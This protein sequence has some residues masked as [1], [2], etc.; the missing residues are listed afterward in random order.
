MGVAVDLLILKK[1]LATETGPAS[2]YRGTERAHP[3]HFTNLAES[4]SANQL[5]S[6]FVEE[7][8]PRGV[9][10]DV[11]RAKQLTESLNLFGDSVF[12]EVVQVGTER[13]VTSG[14]GGFL[15]F[16]V[17]ATF[18]SSLLRRLLL[19]ES[20]PELRRAADATFKDLS[21]LH[22]VH[23][24]QKLNDHRLFQTAE[25]AEFFLRAARALREVKPTAFE[26]IKLPEYA[27]TSLYRVL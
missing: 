4:H 2:S 10:R 18:H 9:V 15:G 23:F 13:G 1:N 12:Y 22:R 24:T 21:T 5:F 6:W 11:K 14:K 8:G 25:D 26:G 27:V 20:G 19:E 7:G 16:D 17:S 3:V